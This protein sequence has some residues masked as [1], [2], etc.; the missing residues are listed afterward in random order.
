M[1]MAICKNGGFEVAISFCKY[2][3]TD[4]YPVFLTLKKDPK[5]EGRGQYRKTHRGNTVKH[6]DVLRKLC[7]QT[8]TTVTRLEKVKLSSTSSLK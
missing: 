8:S 3:F 1:K 7:F 4:S 2:L 5:R 6:T